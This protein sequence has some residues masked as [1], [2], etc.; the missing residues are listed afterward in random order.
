MCDIL[1]EHGDA[2]ERR[3]HLRHPSYSKPELTAAAP[4]ELW[5]W[6]ITKLKGPATCQLFYLVIFSCYV[7]GWLVVEREQSKVARLPVAESYWKQSV[8]PD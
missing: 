7:V 2:R 1:R 5:S 4:S 3:D 8:D 6:D